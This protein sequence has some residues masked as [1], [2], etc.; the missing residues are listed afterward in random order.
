MKNALS[1][2]Y[3]LVPTSIHQI[4]KKYKCYIQDQEYLLVQYEDSLEKVNDFYQLSVHLFNMQISCHKIILNI[5]NSAITYINNLPYMLLKVY[6]TGSKINF[7]EILFFSNIMIDS[8][9]FKNL[10]CNSWHDMWIKKVDYL[11]Y[12]ISQI[13]KNYPLIRDSF[14]YFVGLAEN[15]ISFLNELDGYTDFFSI[16]HKRINFNGDVKELYNPLNFVLDSKVRDISEYIKDKFFKEQYSIY[17]FVKDINL[18]NLN[19]KQYILLYGRLLFPSYYFDIYENIISGNENEKSLNKILAK[20][21]NYNYFLK[22]VWI[23][24]NKYYKL[25]EIEWIIKM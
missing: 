9:K 22:N 21:N 4:N 19:E 24:I 5:N 1:Y 14:N 13:G 20:I 15:S 7:D 10:V 3:N 2:Y 8:V 25:P 18:C 12:Q 6:K 16:C 17:E 23:E 11:E